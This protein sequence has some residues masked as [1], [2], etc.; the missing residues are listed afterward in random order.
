[1]DR[2][3][4][5]SSDG[6]AGLPPGGY[7]EY[8]DPQFRETF[9][10]AMKQQ[11]EMTRELEKHFLVKEINEDWRQGRDRLLTGAWDSDVR[12]EVMDADGVAGEVIF[13]DGITEMNAPPFGAG[14]GLTPRGAVREL[15]W[16]GARSH[17][18]W[19]A[20]FCQMAPER[21]R[22][23]AIVPATWDVDEAV[24]EVR[25]ARENGLGSIM[26]PVM[27]GEHEPYHHPC[28][29]PLWRACEE[30]GM[31]VHF[32]S[33]PADSE[34]YFGS[35]PPDPSKPTLRGAMG[36][37]VS[38]VAWWVAR[39]L[40]FLIWGGIFEDFPGLR[41]AITEG[42]GIWVPSYLELL[43]NRASDH[44]G[45]A[46]LGD[47]KS[48]LTLKPS[49]YFARN[50]RVG[51]STARPE[52]E[53]RHE[54]GL[55]SLMWGSDYP[56]PEGTWPETSSRLHASFHGVPEAEV[57]SILGGN[58]AELYGFDVEKL[59]PLVARIGPAKSALA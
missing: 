9:D 50:C 55:G 19:V 41:V 58:A 10:V 59:A 52:V 27:W 32:H 54:I 6:H 31:V 30:L 38:E 46:K 34:Q 44:P 43:D 18:R 22:G 5:L 23:V 13:P 21:R 37:Y 25:W 36:I 28:Y 20:E 51:S 4:V 16:A 3:L 39:P 15:Q 56:H 17:N 26:I 42:T 49:E 12:N 8:L 29:Q 57:A 14:I 11:I 24:R 1:M 40:T 7:R 48:H 45:N 2:Y 35:W 53:A 33:G 47:Y